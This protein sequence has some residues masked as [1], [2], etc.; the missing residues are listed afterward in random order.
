MKSVLISI[1]PQGA[2]RDPVTYKFIERDYT[3][4]ESKL[5]KCWRSFLNEKDTYL[6][7]KQD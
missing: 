7:L 6:L 1:R 3:V 2:F 4:T 5:T